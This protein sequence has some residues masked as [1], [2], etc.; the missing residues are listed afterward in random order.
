METF[1][2]CI[3][4]FK[5]KLL[6]HLT[7]PLFFSPVLLSPHQTV[8]PFFF[9]SLPLFF[10]TIVF[11]QKASQRKK[12]KFP[13]PQP[14]TQHCIPSL[15]SH[16][17]PTPAPVCFFFPFVKTIYIFFLKKKINKGVVQKKRGSVFFIIIITIIIGYNSKKKMNVFDGGGCGS[18]FLK[19]ISFLSANFF[20]SD[21]TPGNKRVH[22]DGLLF[23]HG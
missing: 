16:H 7:H 23:D 19:K 8:P 9:P 15:L 17:P 2:F 22:F 4:F 1:F 21:K 11:A 3:F 12:K 14:P 5:K 20:F 13:S 10:E 6:P 18:F